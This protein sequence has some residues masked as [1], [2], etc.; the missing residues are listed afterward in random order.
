MRRN[1][2]GYGTVKTLSKNRSRPYMPMVT[3]GYEAPKKHDISFLKPALP[4]ELY[5]EVKSYYDEYCKTALGKA[6]QIQK[7]LG[8][9]KDKADAMIALAEYNKNPYDIDKRDTTFEQIY[10]ILYEQ[11][12]SK[13]K[14]QAKNSYVSS[15]K[16]CDSIKTMRMSDIRKGHMQKVIEEHEDKSVST[17]KNIIKLFHSVFNFALE[18]D[19]CEKDYSKF[20]VA[21]SE[22]EKREKRPFTRTE[23]I[24][25]WEAITDDNWAD[26]LL[27]MIYTGMRISE[28][29]ALT[30]DDIHLEER[31]I[32]VRGTKTKAANRLVPIHKKIAPL[33]KKRLESDCSYLF[34]LSLKKP[35][36]YTNYKEYFDAIMEK[37]NMKHT[38]HECRHSFATYAA[39]SKLNP[40]LVKKIIGHSAQDLTQDTYTH[41]FIEDLIEEID[42]FEA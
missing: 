25:L 23:I 40:I 26:S 17:Q 27:I 1:P 38:P 28:L 21:T 16:K 22:K 32:E 11:K 42:K 20:V 31:Y 36:A 29:L 35:I 24:E 39:S 3:V 9:Y 6:K 15:F 5:N 2:N 30:K 19:V 12:F 34:T 14:R 8:Y 41:A 33:L 37:L 4:E 18:N 7:S 13:M 10:D